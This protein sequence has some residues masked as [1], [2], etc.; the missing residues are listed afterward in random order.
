MSNLKRIRE[1]RNITQIQL[2]EKSGV[3]I[4]MISYY[5]QGFKDINKAQGLTLRALAN[6]LECNIEELLNE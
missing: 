2:A 3:N 1:E 5:E 4:R 6:A